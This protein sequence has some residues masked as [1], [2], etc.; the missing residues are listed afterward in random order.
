MSDLMS[1]L[2]DVSVSMRVPGVG[3]VV[4]MIRD[5]LL[6]CSGESVTTGLS[7]PVAVASV[8]LVGGDVADALVQ[9]D[10]VPAVSER[11]EFGSHDDDVVDRVEVGVLGFEVPEERLDLGL[12]GRR[13]GPPVVGGEPAQGHEL[14]GRS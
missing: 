1:L 9:T 11:V 2:R 8:F 5:A 6:A 13:A 10:G 4:A 7:D 3:V 12:V 14:A